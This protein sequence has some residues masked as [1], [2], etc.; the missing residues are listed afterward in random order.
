MTAPAARTALIG[1][2]GFVG[3][4]LLRQARF[5]DLYHSANAHELAGRSYARLV[6]AGASSLKWKANKEPEADWRAIQALMAALEKVEAR[7]VILISTIDVYD[8]PVGVDEDS[9]VKPEAMM[10]YG[11]HRWALEQF[12]TQRF[13]KTVVVRL[14]N[15]FGEGLKK[16]LVYDLLHQ[17][18]VH[19]IHQGGV[20]Q[21]YGLDRLWAD[22]CQVV[23]RGI[24]LI[25]VATEPW[26][27]RQL[28][29]EV[30]G[31]SLPEQVSTPAPR[32]D[33]RS[34]HASLW[35]GAGGYLYDLPTVRAQLIDFVRRE[36]E[37]M[38]AR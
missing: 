4:N 3:G 29:E 38:G 32:Y 1:S 9:P 18:E 19:K 6:C 22:I 5:D 20:L 25:N 31:V 17:H 16:N 12:V 28:A 33:F 21:W 34:R 35:G 7:E 27:T 26:P 24:S 8:D 30:F 36:R 23:E 15:L 11:K 14:P 2:T 13:S 10:P 37:R